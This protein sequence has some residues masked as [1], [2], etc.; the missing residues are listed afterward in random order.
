MNARRSNP[1]QLDFLE[2]EGARSLL[3]Q[4]LSDAELYTTTES[5]REL[6]AFV[7]R[8]RNFAPFNAMLLHIQKPGLTYAASAADWR[9][10]F[11][12]HIKPGA[13]PLLIMWPFGPVALV[14]DVLDTDGSPLPED[15]QTFF[16]RGEVDDGKLAHIDRLLGRKGIETHHI[17]AGDGRAGAI[18]VLNRPADPKKPT[19]Y[20]LT[21]NRNHPPATRFTTIAHELAHLFLGHL[22]PDKF[23]GVPARPRPPRAEEEVEAESVASLAHGTAWRRYRKPI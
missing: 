18:Q 20:R 5:Y 16:A 3:D 7:A 23:L 22:G 9:S 19:N 1:A 17:D 15:V 14:Y 6:I 10:R 11:K 2:A 8:L 12:R 4:L 13:R 21:L